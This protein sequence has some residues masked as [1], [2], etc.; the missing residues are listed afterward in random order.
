MATANL[1]FEKINAHV[2][3]ADLAAFEKGGALYFAPPKGAK[4]SPAEIVDKLCP[5]YKIVKPILEG[6]LLIP[7]IPASWKAALGIF[8]KIMDKVCEKG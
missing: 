1:T 2:Q 4:L 3:K 8:I 5:I 6:L 7:F